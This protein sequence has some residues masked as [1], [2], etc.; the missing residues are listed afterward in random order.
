MT[1]KKPYDIEDSEQT[2]IEHLTELRIRLV[3][4]L[5]AIGIMTAFAF[6]FNE[7][8]FDIIRRPIAPFL[9]Q[10]NGALIFTGP[11]DKFSAAIKVSIL[12]GIIL[13]TPLWMY[14]VWRFVA[15][16][17]YKHERKAGLLFISVGSFLFLLG[18]SFV[19]FFVYPFAFDFLLNFGGGTD[20]AMITIK[21]Y[22]GF[23]VT[24]TLLFGLAFELPLFLTIAGF[25]GLIDRKFLSEKRPYAIVILALVAAMLTPPDPVSMVVMLIPLLILY[26][27]SVISVGFFGSRKASVED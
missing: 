14:Q 12:A 16:G 8:L 17:L 3:R 25:L 15:P 1:K 18:V 6:Y 27:A 13:A 26:E 20:V 24:T 2:L 23:F 21:D 10:S 4:A 9:D 5:L 19:Y 7:I 11:L 22:L